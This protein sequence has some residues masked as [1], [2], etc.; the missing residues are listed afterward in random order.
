MAKKNKNTNEKDGHKNK[1]MTIVKGT[2]FEVS[3][4]C[5]TGGQ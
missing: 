5:L 1:V 3:N 2:A 4:P